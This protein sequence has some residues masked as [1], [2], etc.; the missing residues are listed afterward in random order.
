MPKQKSKFESK[1]EKFKRIAALRTQKILNYIK[2]L[3]NCSNKV[4]YSYTQE[5]ISKIFNAIEKELK[6]VKTL[7]DKPKDVFHL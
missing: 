1:E 5:D 3:G 4:N 7:F 2:L 6:R